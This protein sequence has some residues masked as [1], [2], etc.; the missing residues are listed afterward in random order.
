MCLLLLYII[1]QSIK[2]K[3][4]L[5]ALLG[6]NSSRVVFGTVV[7]D[8]VYIPRCMECQDVVRNPMEIRLLASE[9]IRGS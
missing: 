3:E 2:T 6:V 4:A 1:F 9:L 7:A 5:L 8:H